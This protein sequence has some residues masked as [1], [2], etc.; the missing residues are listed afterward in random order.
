[1]NVRE[2]VITPRIPEGE[3]LVIESQEMQNR[4]VKIMNMD[5]VFNGFETEIIRGA[6]DVPTFNAATGEPHGKTIVVVIS[7]VHF[8][9]VGTSLWQ[10]DRRRSPEFATP[11]H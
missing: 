1:M 10:L 11:H 7:A 4:G 5:G 6:V 8:P 3:F 9:S 2:P